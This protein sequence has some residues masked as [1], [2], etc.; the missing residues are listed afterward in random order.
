MRLSLKFYFFLHRSTFDSCGNFPGVNDA[1]DCCKLH[2]IV[3][4]LP[5]CWCVDVIV[6][7]IIILVVVVL[8]SCQNTQ[9]AKRVFSVQLYYYYYYYLHRRVDCAICFSTFCCFYRSGVTG[10]CISR[11]EDKAVSP[12]QSEFRNK[13]IFIFKSEW[14]RFDSKTKNKLEHT[15]RHTGSANV[16]SPEGLWISQNLLLGHVSLI[17]YWTLMYPIEFHS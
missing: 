16:H 3:V 12:W 14:I 9:R 10:S 1:D 8:N 6:C 13:Q 17:S 5:L 11:A 2:H 15:H 7:I 4:V